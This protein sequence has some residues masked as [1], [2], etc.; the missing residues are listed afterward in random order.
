MKWGL[1]GKNALKV[2][3]DIAK[4]SPPLCASGIGGSGRTQYFISDKKTA[5]KRMPEK[6]LY[7]IPLMQEINAITPNGFNVISTFSGCGGSSL[8]YR[9][10]GFKVLWANEF[11]PAAQESYRANMQADCILDG[12]D[13]RII[14][15]E[16]ILSTIGL[17]KGQLDLLDG[18]PPCQAFSAA[19]KREKGWGK[20]KHYEHGA[21]QC[22]ERLFDEYIRLLGGL[23]PKVFVAENVSGLVKG[24]AK[25]MFL[26][27]L[28]GLKN[29]GYKV[30][31]RV[32]D[33]QW[34]G[35]PQSPKEQ[36]LSACVMT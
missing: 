11:V 8:G 13:I 5:E 35:V 23:M 32:L 22:N 21:T 17:K 15:P 24:A 9:M 3:V 1:R 6:P 14:K 19:G 28:A 18:S 36:S 2:E 20:A 26:E 30:T 29:C 34:L 33:A 12:R 10:A 16:D 4:P 27:I 7:K 31:C 25:G